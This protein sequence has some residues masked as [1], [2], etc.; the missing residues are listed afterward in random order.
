MKKGERETK[1]G[2]RERDSGAESES[3]GSAVLQQGGEGA[4]G[5]S[6]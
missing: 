5:L 1:K 6:S 4:G 3:A 2:E